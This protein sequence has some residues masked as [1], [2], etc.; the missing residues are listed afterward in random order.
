[1]MSLFL[2]G[3]WSRFQKYIIIAAIIAG[4][5][6]YLVLVGVNRERRRNALAAARKMIE[7]QA[8]LDRIRRGQAAAANNRP[9]DDSLNKTLDDGAF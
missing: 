5:A 3:L 2:L 9:D 6:G 4:V 1:M 7:N 8:K